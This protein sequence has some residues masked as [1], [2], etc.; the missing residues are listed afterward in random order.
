MSDKEFL[1]KA[2]IMEMINQDVNSTTPLTPDNLVSIRK[3][4]A[5]KFMA[6]KGVIMSLAEASD[7][8]ET[9]AWKDLWAGVWSDPPSPG[10]SVSV[11]FTN[12]YR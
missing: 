11:F 5:V 8:I 9:E 6:H 12:Q 2:Y 1:A 10:K 7:Y 3:V 4:C